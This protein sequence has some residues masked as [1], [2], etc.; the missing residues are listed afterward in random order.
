MTRFGRKKAPT[1]VRFKDFFMEGHEDECWLWSGAPDRD[2]YGRLWVYEEKKTRGAHCYAWEQANQ[3]RVPTGMCVCHTCDTRLCVN[4]RHLWLG[5]NTE[6]TQDKV[7]KGR[8]A[9]GTSITSNR[10][11]VSK[12]KLCA[13][14]VRRMRSM[15]AE[16]ASGPLVASTFG[17][18]ASMANAVRRGTSWSHVA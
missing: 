17:V 13:D 5:T 6:N 16:G 14:A 18:S 9:R 1:I 11:P 12:R 8:Q 15:F 7:A 3:L 10:K 4:P 2:G